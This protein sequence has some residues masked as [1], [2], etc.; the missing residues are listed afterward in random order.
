MGRYTVVC[1]LSITSVIVA[2]CVAP[3]PS[4]GS[5]LAEACR[6][7]IGV[8]GSY[9]YDGSDDIPV[10]RPL[11]GNSVLVG[12]TEEEAARLN[13]CIRTKAA[14]GQTGGT[15][16]ALPSVAGVPQR[17]ETTTSGTTTTQTFTYG[18]PPSTVASA[19]AGRAS[20]P[21]RSYS[22]CVD[23]GGPLQGGTGYCTGN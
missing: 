17:V 4:Q 20:A 16:T 7:E 2:G 12:G 23:G 14:T 6:A 10:V 15:A 3:P 5:L 19:R 1:L 9:N 21:G 11:R 8:V 13:A 22:G 18:T